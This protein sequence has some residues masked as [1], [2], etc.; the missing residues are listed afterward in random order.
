MNR[1]RRRREKEEEEKEKEGGRREEG[2]GG[3]PIRSTSGARGS[4][5][6][7]NRPPKTKVVYKRL[8]DPRAAGGDSPSDPYAAGGCDPRRRGAGRGGTAR[9]TGTRPEAATPG[10]GG[11]EE[12]EEG[13]RKDDG[14]HSKNKNPI[15]TMWGKMVHVIH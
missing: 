1:R 11:G 15:Q 3:G 6:G 14:V 12:E 5:I 8:L 4:E 7:G 9:Q 2:E 10:G 13:G